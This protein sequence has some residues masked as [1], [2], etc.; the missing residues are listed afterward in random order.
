MAITADHIRDKLTKELAAVHVDVED[1]SPNR[2]AAS[3]KVLVVS[4]QF[5]GKPLLQRHRLVNTCLAEELK[6]IHAF[7]QKT[8][9]PEQWE[10]QKAQ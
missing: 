4:S 3:Y 7:E 2:C 8:L 1:T 5:E 10:K 9:T 6:E